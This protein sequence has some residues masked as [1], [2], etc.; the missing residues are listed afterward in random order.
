LQTQFIDLEPWIEETSQRTRPIPSVNRRRPLKA[1]IYPGKGHIKLAPKELRS[2]IER[3]RSCLIR[4]FYPA[5]KAA[6][7]K[8]LATSDLLISYDPISS[9]AFEANLLGIPV[10][11]PVGWDE[12]DFKE[13]FPVDLSGI[14]WNDLPQFLRLL[15]NGFNQK[16][17]VDSYRAALS[18][19]THNLLSLLS[20]AFTDSDPDNA[21]D[22]INAYWDTRQPF[23]ASLNLPSV[24]GWETMKEAL[25]A[26]TMPELMHDILECTGRQ[27]G[28]FNRMFSARCRGIARRLRALLISRAD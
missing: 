18:K 10:Y 22:A 13:S 3:S 23:F 9:L 4:R 16:P 27:I 20:F 6:L 24:A 21:A 17:I 7:Y 19:N 26:S 2:L 8:E 12:A 5:T 25:P 15:D 28:R 1:S 11:I 14:V